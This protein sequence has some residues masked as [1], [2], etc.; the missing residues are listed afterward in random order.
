FEDIR[1]FDPD[2]GQPAA[3]GAQRIEG[4]GH[5]AFLGESASRASSHSWR[6]TMEW[7]IAFSFDYRLDARPM[8][9]TSLSQG[10]RW[11]RLISKCIAAM[12]PTGKKPGS[13]AQS[14]AAEPSR[15]ASS[16][17]SG[18]TGAAAKARP[19]A[20]VRS[21]RSHELRVSAARD[22]VIGRL[23]LYG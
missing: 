22:V 5:G 8:V 21:R 23:P 7:S 17:M 4:M 20:V 11:K 6:E 14:I 3:L 15:A 18:K 1:L 9:D 2:P 16:A 13:R 10:G 12:P 19:A